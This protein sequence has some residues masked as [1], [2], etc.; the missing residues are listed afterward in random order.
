MGQG[1]GHSVCDYPDFRYGCVAAAGDLI[2][3]PQAIA[4][5]LMPSNRGLQHR[6]TADTARVIGKSLLGPD[7]SGLQSLIPSSS[8]S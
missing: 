7:A 8:S 1:Q 3:G 5:S 2:C 4:N 6:R